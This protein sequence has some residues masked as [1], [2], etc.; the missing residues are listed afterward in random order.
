MYYKNVSNSLRSKDPSS[1]ANK[2]LNSKNNF[3]E[4]GK[5]IKKPEPFFKDSWMKSNKDQSFRESVEKLPYKRVNK[6][7][8]FQMRSKI[9][10]E[11][12]NKDRLNISFDNVLRDSA[13]FKNEDE[14]ELTFGNSIKKQSRVSSMNNMNIDYN[15]LICNNCLN[16]Q[17]GTIK[18]LK[19]K[20]SDSFLN[21]SQ[22]LVSKFVL[23]SLNLGK[24]Q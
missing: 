9:N 16:T 19:N 23:N 17:L 8:P 24:F 15:K 10:L 22:E 6:A 13:R 3:D 14:N 21:N 2:F 12:S 4:S 1:F 18:K 5:E 7:P 11:P 20:D